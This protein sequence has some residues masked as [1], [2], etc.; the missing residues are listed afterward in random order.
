MGEWFHVINTSTPGD[1]AL[2]LASTD[3]GVRGSTTAKKGMSMPDTEYLTDLPLAGNLLTD[4][5]DGW[6]DWLRTEFD[7]PAVF[8]AVEHLDSANT[9]PIGAESGTRDS[10]PTVRKN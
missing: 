1:P 6:P 3:P 5:F 8:T 9:P 2:R 7:E 4:D 10:R